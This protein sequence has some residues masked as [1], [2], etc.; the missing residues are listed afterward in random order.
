MWLE[1]T[2]SSDSQKRK[3]MTLHISALCSSLDSLI[4]VGFSFIRLQISPVPQTYLGPTQLHRTQAGSPAPDSSSSCN[5]TKY[6]SNNTVSQK[7]RPPLK[8]FCSRYSH[9]L[10]ISNDAQH[11]NWLDYGQGWKIFYVCCSG[12]RYRRCIPI[13][14]Q[15]EALWHWQAAVQT[16]FQGELQ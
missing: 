2:L 16:T 7:R 1:R 6:S 5:L 3:P 4:K 13:S 12:A 14:A 11:I 10:T 9:D 8:T 15:L